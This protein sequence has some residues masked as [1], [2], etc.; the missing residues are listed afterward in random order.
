MA[1]PPHDPRF[2]D[3]TETPA[4]R[5]AEFDLKN[6]PDARLIARRGRRAHDS[7]GGLTQFF[8]GVAAFGIGTY[9]LFARVMVSAGISG[10]GMFGVG[11]G[12]GPHLGLTLLPFIAGIIVLFV[13]GS[14]MLGW[15]L[16]GG[17]ILLL[18]VQIIA[19]MQMHFMATPLPIVLLIVGLMASGV[20]LIARSLRGGDDDAP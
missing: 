14:G 4:D 13:Q 17:G 5:Y 19:S 1:N 6:D 2:K 7:S 9:M 3:R 10:A 15:S 18:I 16:M 12:S 8:A 11:F 20:G